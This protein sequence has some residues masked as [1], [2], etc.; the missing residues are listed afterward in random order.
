MARGDVDA[1]TALIAACE[2]EDLGDV[3]IDADDVL[4]GFERPEFD[5]ATDAIVVLRDRTLVAWAEVY[6]GRSEA[7]VQPAHRGRGL[8]RALLRWTERRAAGLRSP[9]VR[10]IVPD[11]I[12]AASLLRDG[13][14]QR[15]STSWILQIAFEDVPPQAPAVP[16]GITIRAYAPGRDER[17]VYGVVEDAFNEWEGREPTAFEEWRSS[18]VGHGSFAPAL[19]PLA[20]D[21]NDL[22]GAA[23]AL[24]YRDSDEGWI[25]QLATRATH[26]RRGVARA[27]LQTAFG[28]FY[29]RGKVR[30]GLSTDSRTGALALYERLGMSVRRSYSSYEKE[31]SFGPREAHAE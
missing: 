23:L 4:V 11:G 25:Q 24:D 21:G 30:S 6:K 26:R 10:Q 16:D 3:E 17:A 13:G 19:S 12:P 18:M 27:L 14:Y 5:P 1:V 2:R 29:A 9:R 8:G 31:L 7:D 28:A 22:V 20:F 15:S